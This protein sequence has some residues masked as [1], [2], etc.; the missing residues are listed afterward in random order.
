MIKVDTEYFRIVN[1]IL[2]SAEENNINQFT[3]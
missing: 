3:N 1:D 2:T